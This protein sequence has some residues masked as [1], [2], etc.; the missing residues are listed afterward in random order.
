ML[1]QISTYKNP[2]CSNKS[3]VYPSDDLLYHFSQKS[4]KM[5]LKISKAKNAC[6]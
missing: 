6:G 1:A 5:H 2:P 3:I 4:D